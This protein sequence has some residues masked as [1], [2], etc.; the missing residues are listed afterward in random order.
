MGT[1]V[2]I[3]CSHTAGT[4][5]DGVTGSQNEFNLYNCFAAQIARK[6]NYQYINLSVPGGSNQSI[7]RKLNFYIAENKKDLE[8]TFFL[9]GWTTAS[10]FELRYLENSPHNFITINPWVDKKYIPFTHK[11]DPKLLHTKT[12][13]DLTYYSPYLFHPEEDENNWAVYVYSAQKVLE[14]LNLKYY[15]VNTCKEILKTKFNYSIINKL[16][17]DYYLDPLD[18]EMSL[19]WWALKKGYEKTECW[20]LK[21]DAHTEWANYIYEKIEDAYQQKFSK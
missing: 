21:L 7:L 3:G 6:M 19:L 18:P 15:M 8:N 14:N 9:L 5:L 12:P 10:R 11:M 16:N 1:L 2:A 13:K 17:K 4:A 20:H